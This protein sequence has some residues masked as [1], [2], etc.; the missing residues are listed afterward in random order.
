M[1]YT[2]QLLEEDRK[3]GREEGVQRGKLEAVE[4]IPPG[5]R[6]LAT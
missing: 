4:G 3:E 1:S 2:Q 5:L 6:L